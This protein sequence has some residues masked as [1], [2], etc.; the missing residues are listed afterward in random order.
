MVNTGIHWYSDYPLAIILGYSF[1][2]LA[3]HPEGL[4]DILGSE[5]EEKG[6]KLSPGFGYNGMN[7]NLKYSF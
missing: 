1:G 2:M 4:H 7:L 5:N 3:S 6:F